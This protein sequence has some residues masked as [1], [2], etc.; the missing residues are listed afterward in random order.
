MNSQK[1]HSELAIIYAALPKIHEVLKD[2]YYLFILENRGHSWYLKISGKLQLV[3][4]PNLWEKLSIIGFIATFFRAI[5]VAPQILYLGISTLVTKNQISYTKIFVSIFVTAL[6]WFFMPKL[7]R[8][9]GEFTKIEREKEIFTQSLY[10]NQKKSESDLIRIEDLCKNVDRK[11]LKLA[12]ANIKILLEQ[13]Q[14]SAN[15]AVILSPILAIGLVTFIIYTMG[16]AVVFLGNPL[17][18]IAIV[19]VPGMIIVTKPLSEF[20][21]DL[22]LP[23]DIFALQ[24]IAFLLEQAQSLAEAIK[25]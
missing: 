4:A 20:I 6:L 14:A 1:P 22:S 7:L 23:S 2:D 9:I 17:L 16:I 11:T 21:F 13:K 3:L 15:V 5:Y 24:R 18:Y 19:G 25:D 12:L 8:T 10:V